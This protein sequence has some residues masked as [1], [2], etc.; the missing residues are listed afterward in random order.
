MRRAEG[1]ATA[2]VATERFVEE[3]QGLDGLACA[4]LCTCN[5]RLATADY[6]RISLSG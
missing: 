1:K 5:V 6:D 3:R 4:V 2:G